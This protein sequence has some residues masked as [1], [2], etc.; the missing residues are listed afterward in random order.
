MFVPKIEGPPGHGSAAHVILCKEPAERDHL[1]EIG[2]GDV[3]HERNEIIVDRRANLLDQDSAREHRLS[4]S[5]RHDALAALGPT[6][7]E[8]QLGARQK[9]DK[10]L[11][12]GGFVFFLFVK[13]EFRFQTGMGGRLQKHP[14]LP[15]IAPHITE[16]DIS[17]IAGG[18]E[19]LL[20][21]GRRRTNQN[22]CRILQASQIFRVTVKDDDDITYPG[23]NNRTIN[24]AR[25]V[26]IRNDD[27]QLESKLRFKLNKTSASMVRPLGIVAVECY[28]AGLVSAK[29]CLSLSRRAPETAAP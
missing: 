23:A 8:G 14:A 24:K 12:P 25:I 18:T 21:K 1:I 27:Q 26:A 7:V 5:C 15:R 6:V 28:Y 19:R 10:L 20:V 13:D 3:V 2:D 11:A 16:L 17:V 29:C 22:A 9:I 4:D